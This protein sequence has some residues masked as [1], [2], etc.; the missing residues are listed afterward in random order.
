MYLVNCHRNSVTD[1]DALRFEAAHGNIADV[2]IENFHMTTELNCMIDV[3]DAA[4]GKYELKSGYRPEAYQAHLR[5]VY[6]AWELLENRRDPECKVLRDEVSVE[7]DAH[8][9]G[10]KPAVKSDHTRGL[11]FDLAI[12]DLSSQQIDAAADKC[13]LVRFDPIDDPNHFARPRR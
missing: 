13:V 11:A 6:L 5:E 12:S 9:L 1:L 4:D 2:G 8:K 7:N 10:F 3:V